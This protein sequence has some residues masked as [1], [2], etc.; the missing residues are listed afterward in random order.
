MQT[1]AT[2]SYHFIVNGAD[3]KKA[4]I[5]YFVQFQQYYSFE[6]GG[7]VANSNLFC[8]TKYI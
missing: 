6:K 4:L 3:K 2:T 1:N 5:Q 7:L 8:D